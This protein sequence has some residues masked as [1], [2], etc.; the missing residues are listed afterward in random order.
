MII[1]IINSFSHRPHN[2]HLAYLGAMLS[3]LNH[4]VLYAN[5][6][7]GSDSCNT[8]ITKK[9]LNNKPLTCFICKEFGLKSVVNSKVTGLSPNNINKNCDYKDIALSTLFTATR[10]ETPD[11]IKNIKEHQEFLK[12]TNS[13][14]AYYNSVK[15]WVS[16]NDIDM[17]FGYNGRIDLM[18]AARLAVMDMNKIFWTVERPWFGKGLLITPN[19]G[20]TGTISLGNM[21]NAFID[22]PLN[23]SQILRAVESMSKRK[24][25]LNKSEF[26]NFNKGHNLIDWGKINSNGKYK[27]LFLPSSRMESISE[28]DY[29][30]DAWSHPLDGIEKLINNKIISPEDL[31]IRFHP[32]WNVE[33]YNKDAKSCINYYKSFCDRLQIKYIR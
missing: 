15:E 25:Q 9:I 18:R 31:I 17:V 1:G 29:G 14:F 24:L 10:T 4:N 28:V 26:M 27:Y 30:K 23:Y 16:K 22:K 6:S 33:L 7:G 13:C 8:L 5:C 19:E 2:Q 12:L 21:F 11:E 20:P 32:V 3:K